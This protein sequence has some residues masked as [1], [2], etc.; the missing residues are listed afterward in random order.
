M[1]P[2]KLR[3]EDTDTARSTKL[4]EED[5]IESFQRVDLMRDAWPWKDDGH[6]PYYQMQRL[7]IYNRYVQDLLESWHAYYAWESS[8]ELTAMRDA[9][10]AQKTAFNYRKPEYSQDQIKAFKAEGRVPVIRF[11]VPHWTDAREIQFGRYGQGRN[12]IQ[13]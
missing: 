5:I 8:E 12:Y 4:F 3:V 1:E 7:E 2:Y 10:H 6:G 11:A 13:H 9:A